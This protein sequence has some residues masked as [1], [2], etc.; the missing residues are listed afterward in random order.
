MQDALFHIT[1]RLR[2]IIFPGR[3]PFSGSNFSPFPEMHH[4]QFRPRHG[5]GSP[6]PYHSPVGPYHNFDHQHPFSYG[7]DHGG[8][9][10]DRGP[11]PY[12]SERPGH[13]PPFEHTP[14]SWTSQVSV[15]Y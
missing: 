10:M 5:P 6:D 12:G 15:D 2:D 14:R 3:P 9:N 8:P 7:M 4:S 1:G 13:G 11:F